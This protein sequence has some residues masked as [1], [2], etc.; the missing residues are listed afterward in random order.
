MT[1]AVDMYQVGLSTTDITPPVGIYLAG[2]GARQDRSTGVYHP[3][4][5]T[6]IAIHDGETPLLLVAADLLGFY[7]LTEPVR[8][9]IRDAVGL[10]PPHVAL[11]GSHT[12]CGPSIRDLDRERHG[13]LDPEYLDG[14]VESVV[15]CA[16]EA[17]ES[18]TSARLRAGVGR[19]GFAVS[20]RAPDG[21]G[22]IVW[23]PSRSAPSDHDV[24]VLAVESLEGDLRAVV[25]S[26]AC[27]P[28]S[29]GG[30]LIGGDYVGFAYAHVEETHPGVTA[31]FLQGCG[32]DQKPVPVDPEAESF[33]PSEVEEVRDIGAELGTVVS[34]VL[35]SDAMQPV[36]GPLTI[37]QRTI[38]LETDPVDMALLEEKRDSD[39]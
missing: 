32:G 19:C 21:E 11:C 12:H 9:G 8:T 39:Q 18:R 37:T 25:F 34:E 31:C 36:E 7:E 29:R 20:R 13:E 1:S 6:A 26:Y 15:R 33:V 35:G 3:L 5:A 30:L 22:G 24:P 4:R 14:L 27:H 2:F 16:E 10:D 23:K 17:W 28:T 38:D